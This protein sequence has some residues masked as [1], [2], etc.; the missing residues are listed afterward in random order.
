[1]PCAWMRKHLH[2]TFQFK[3]SVKLLYSESTILMLNIHQGICDLTPKNVRMSVIGP[4]A[5]RDSR[6][7]TIA[8]MYSIF[9]LG[10]NMI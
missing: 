6:V 9:S 8:S 4:D 10:M 7:S 3:R 5:K 1:M 2:E